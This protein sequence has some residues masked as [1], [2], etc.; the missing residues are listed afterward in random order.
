MFDGKFPCV[1][2]KEKKLHLMFLD[3]FANDEVY[4]DMCGVTFVTVRAEEPSRK[5]V[6]LVKIVDR[7]FYPIKC[8]K[9]KSL[10]AHSV[11]EE[12]PEIT[13]DGSESSTDEYKIT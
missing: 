9:I 2:I 13:V 4:K 8:I 3:L 7:Y 10:S 5:S 11:K 1:R 12:K 6:K